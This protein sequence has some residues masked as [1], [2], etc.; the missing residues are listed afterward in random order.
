MAY[1]FGKKAK[2][3][4]TKHLG[5]EGATEFMAGLQHQ[6]IHVMGEMNPPPPSAPV[7]KAKKKPRKKKA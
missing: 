2:E 5:K 3:Y 1:T 6:D 4:I 7:V